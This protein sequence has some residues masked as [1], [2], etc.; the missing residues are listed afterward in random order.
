ML[1][2]IVRDVHGKIIE[3]NNTVEMDAIPHSDSFRKIVMSMF[4][5]GREEYNEVIKILSDSHHILKFEITKEDKDKGIDHVEGYVDANLDSVRRLKSLYQSYLV[6]A[7]EKQFN[8]RLMV[9]QIIKEIFPRIRTFNNTP[10]GHVANKAIMLSEY[11]KLLEKEYGEFTKEWKDKKLKDILK[12]VHEE[13]KLFK[14][15]IKEE[16][17]SDGP[18]RAIDSDEYGDYKK[19]KESLKKVL[20]IYG[21]DFFYRVNLRKYNF[22]VIKEAISSREIDQRG[23]LKKLKDMLKK[24]KLNTKRD[25]KL[26]EYFD[27]IYALERLISKHIVT[28]K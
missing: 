2:K 1:E 26:T 25:P 21:V 17:D 5:L 11:E 12:I 15:D 6:E 10:L 3:R 7:Y 27:D 4:G 8:T 16:E 23:D 28:A 14:K 24:M 9:H 20:S 18:R 22:D 19:N 13:S